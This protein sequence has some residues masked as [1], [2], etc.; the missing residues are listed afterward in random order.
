MFPPTIIIITI[1][2]LSLRLILSQNVANYSKITAIGISKFYSG[3]KIYFFNADEPTFSNLSITEQSEKIIINNN[4]TCTVSLTSLAINDTFFTFNLS[5]I[6]ENNTMEYDL[7]NKKVNF[8]YKSQNYSYNYTQNEQFSYQIFTMQFFLEST[9]GVFSI[10]KFMVLFSGLY[11]SFYGYC[12]NFTVSTLFIQYFLFILVEEIYE[13]VFKTTV[14]DNEIIGMFLFIFSLIIGG[15]LGILFNLK[16]PK[17]LPFI[18]TF[19]AVFCVSKILIY[20][21]PYQSLAKNYY[22][23]L[24]SSIVL[25]V[26]ISIAVLYSSP[27]VK[28]NSFLLTSSVIGAYLIICGVSYTVGGII[29]IKIRNNFDEGQLPSDDKIKYLIIYFS[30]L[31]ISVIFQFFQQTFDTSK[32]KLDA[33]KEEFKK[34]NSNDTS[35]SINK[36]RLST[37]MENTFRPSDVGKMLPEDNAQNPPELNQEEPFTDVH[38]DEGYVNEENLE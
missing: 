31:I 22:T 13:N 37:E 20:L 33:E 23:Y 5:C 29:F 9:R 38:D 30:F 15:A 3:D 34:M 28:K 14:I 32:S 1:F 35:N 18:Y 8:I 2:A 19:S 25:A 12:N 7:K 11:V 27:R 16:F 10:I 17:S 6:N 21:L 26:M 4:D 36:P 24:F